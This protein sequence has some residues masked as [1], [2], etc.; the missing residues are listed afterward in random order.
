MGDVQSGPSCEGLSVSELHSLWAHS[1][2][3]GT[4]RWHGLQDHLRGTAELAQRFA[5]PFGGSDVAYWLGA[6][7][8]IGKAA[9]DWQVKLAAVSGTDRPVGIDH[10][11]LGTKIA[12]E[13]GLA[14]LAV[15]VYGHHGGLIDVADLGG[16]VKDRLGRNPNNAASATA[17]LPWL[18]P[19][20]PANL[21]GLV[22][23]EWRRDPRVGEMAARLCFSALVD[24]DSLDT[25]AHFRQLPTPRVRDDADFGHLYR[26]F[27]RRRSES[28]ALRGAAPVDSLRER[29]YADCVAAA[30]QPSGVFRLGAPTGAGK[31]LAGAGFA[32][33]H[34]ER[35]GK[36]RVIVA[37][38]FLTITEQNA[39]VYRRMLDEEGVES[40][41]LEH[42][43]QANFDDG[44]AGRWARLAAE[45]WGC[46][47]RRDDV[48]AAVRVAVR[49]E[50]VGDAS[51]APAGQCGDRVW[52]RFRRC[53]I[54][55]SRRSLMGFGCWCVI[56][57]RRCCCPQRRSRSSGRWRSS[58]GWRVLI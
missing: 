24:A 33:R 47:V 53:R 58:A 46:S 13:R 48:R 44:Q 23:Q 11:A 3:P 50:A 14:S 16:A 7:H 6:L 1:P 5:A 40:V 27:E 18:L 12:S 22:P 37:V 17:E 2:A 4:A 34:A 8:D 56:S 39:D 55:C 15:A 20:L 32:L 36:R 41:V 29:V 52:T 30:E 51:G 31:T 28:L 49:A 38:P 35:H 45:N 25:G 10:K 57:V 21:A 19:G 42:H 54:R 43:S 26:L 9:C